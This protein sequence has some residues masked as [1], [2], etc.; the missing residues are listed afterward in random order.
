M[1]TVQQSPDIGRVPTFSL[2]AQDIK[3]LEG[4]VLVYTLTSRS[5]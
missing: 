2:I 3:L 4:Y 5:Y 1:F